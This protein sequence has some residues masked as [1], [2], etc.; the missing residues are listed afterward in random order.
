MTQTK[1][2]V[3]A[4][5]PCEQVSTCPGWQAGGVQRMKGVAVTNSGVTVAQVVPQPPGQYPLEQVYTW[6]AWQA[7]GVHSSRGVFTRRAAGGVV[8]GLA[9]KPDEQAV[10]LL[11]INVKTARIDI[12]LQVL[13]TAYD[14][15]INILHRNRSADR[16]HLHDRIKDEIPYHHTGRHV[17]RSR[18]F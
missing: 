1:P 11:A 17:Q 12:I 8:V 7:G 5:S 3:P 2:Q 9:P 18:S 14:H 13:I 4:Q 10:T 16:F 15:H 6:P